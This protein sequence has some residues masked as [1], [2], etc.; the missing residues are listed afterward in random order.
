MDVRERLRTVLDKHAAGRRVLQLEVRKGTGDD[1]SSQNSSG[2][3]HFLWLA[4][5]FQYMCGDVRVM[6]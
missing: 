1:A 5:G 6:L 2:S 4:N 3:G